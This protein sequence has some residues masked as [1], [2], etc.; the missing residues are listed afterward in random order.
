MRYTVYK[1]YAFIHRHKKCHANCRIFRWQ[2]VPFTAVISH[3]SKKTAFS[4]SLYTDRNVLDKNADNRDTIAEV[5]SF[6]YDELK[7]ENE[8]EH[9]SSSRRCQDI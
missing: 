1:S 9:F 3:E 7:V 6:M 5:L 2:P 8:M 4:N